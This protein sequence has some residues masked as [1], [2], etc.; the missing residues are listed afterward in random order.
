M[1]CFVEESFFYI[2]GLQLMFEDG[3]YVLI[4]SFVI[5]S[6]MVGSM[7]LIAAKKEML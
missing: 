3:S 2:V 6:V 1:G 7:I 4:E 5:K